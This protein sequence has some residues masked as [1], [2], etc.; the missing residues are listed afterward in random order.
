MALHYDI[1]NVCKWKDTCYRIVSESELKAEKEYKK[2]HPD[3]VKIFT[4]SRFEEDGVTYEMTAM[5]F[6]LQF[7]LALNIGIGEITEANYEIVY[8]RMHF[9]ET[10]M[11]GNLTNKDEQGNNIEVKTTLEDVKNHIGMKVNASLKQPA[12]FT[13]AT[14]KAW[15]NRNQMEL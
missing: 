5:T 14:I 9:Y 8:A 6:N 13:R 2:K 10:L 11:G 1:T 15:K 3:R 7:M 12:Q 4:M